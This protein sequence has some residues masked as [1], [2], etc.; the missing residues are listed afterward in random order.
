MKFKI[1]ATAILFCI[2]AVLIS[3]TFQAEKAFWESKFVRVNSDGSLNYIPDEKGNILP[4]FSCVGYHQGDKDFPDMPIVKTLSPAEHGSSQQLIQD[5]IDEISKR[6][7][8]KS[9]FRGTILLKKGTYRIPGTIRINSGGIVLR[10]EGSNADR[11]RLIAAG[12]GRRSLLVIS[13]NGSRKEA[14]NT[15]I[16]IADD[17]VP[18]GARSFR[19]E[20]VKGLRP[21]DD[22]VVFRPGTQQ[23]ISDIK[24]DQ[25]IARQ[26]TKQWQPKEYDLHFERKIIKIEGNQIVIDNPVVM[27]METKYGGGEIY[28]YAFDGRIAEVGVEN[29]LFESEYAH[30]TDEDH[31][32]IAVELNKAENCWVKNITSRYFGYACVSVENDA[33]YVTVTDSRSFDPKSVITGGKRYS[34]NNNGQL[35][36]FMNLETTEG[37]HDYVTGARVLGPNVFYNCRSSN[38]HADI[39]P[40]HRWSVGTLYDN[41]TTDGEINIQDRGNWGSGHGWAG[42][43]Q[44]LW[45]CTAKRAAVQSPWASGKNYCIGL[46]GAKY[47]GR[48]ED[49]PDGEWEGLNKPGLEPK[50]LYQAQLKNRQS[51]RQE[52]RSQQ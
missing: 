35:N 8:D 25:I 41:I 2:T 36:L 9:G 24:M 17:Y 29:I 37:R 7:P 38:T 5:A 47:P 6:K 40:H 46:R 22:I 13:G 34:F 16:K 30:D 20:S 12:K 31:G 32:W 50:S 10:G 15:R 1:T 23:W 26:G 48:F 4:D 51:E 44:I 18:V 42:V 27:A 49:K 11:T 3:F 39:G 33:K 28:K 14:A 43:T 21:G 45:N 19:L 52:A